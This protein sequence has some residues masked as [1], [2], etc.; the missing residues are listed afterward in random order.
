[1][2]PRETSLRQLKMLRK[3]TK[4]TD[5]GDITKDDRLNHNVPN[6]QYIGNPIDTGIDSYEEFTEKDSKL[7]TIAFKSKLV[8]K[9]IKEKKINEGM[10][11]KLNNVL[12]FHD[13]EE[14]GWKPEMAHKT[15]R[16]DVAKDI[17]K[18]Y[19]KAD[20]I[21]PKLGDVI[22]DGID[23]ENA[24]LEFI[25]KM[26]KRKNREITESKEEKE[27][28]PFPYGY[29]QQRDTEIKKITE[30]NLID[31]KTPKERPIGGGAG[32][33]VDN[34]KVKGFINRIEGKNVYVE[35]V[36]EPMKIQKFNIKDVVKTKKE[37]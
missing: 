6:L 27:T 37:E 11:D 7:Q 19:S 34:G 15:K 10:K 33:F 30:F 5:I 12:S 36:D 2:L 17:I 24:D 1:M 26:K 4:G 22:D 29:A 28:K 23:D 8:N 13:F 21:E 14:D 9:S 16:T 31:P 18:E 25:K 32:Q 35:S 3:L 20:F